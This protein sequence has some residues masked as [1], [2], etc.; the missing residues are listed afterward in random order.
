[1]RSALDA[2]AKYENV[3]AT[4]RT[5]ARHE[6]LFGPES[7]ETFCPI[8]ASRPPYSLMLEGLSCIGRAGRTPTQQALAIL[9][10]E[11]V[12]RRGRRD[13]GFPRFFASRS[14]DLSLAT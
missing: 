13:C 7:D 8:S 1:M 6:L 2:L 11:V 5:C 9:R 3:P 14:P 4:A 12:A 10:G